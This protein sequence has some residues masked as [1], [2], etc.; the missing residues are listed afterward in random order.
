[1]PAATRVASR[2]GGRGAGDFALV[3]GAASAG[4][5]P[6]APSASRSVCPRWGLICESVSSLPKAPEE[7]DAYLNDPEGRRVAVAIRGS[8]VPTT[9]PVAPR[10][11]HFHRGVACLLRDHSECLRLC[12]QDVWPNP[13][14]SSPNADRRKGQIRTVVLAQLA[15][16]QSIPSQTVCRWRRYEQFRPVAEGRLGA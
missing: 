14:N 2:A 9:R 5:V 15:P 7:R 4:G 6:S 13:S 11:N 3:G 10:R 1:M 8:A 16:R 12:F